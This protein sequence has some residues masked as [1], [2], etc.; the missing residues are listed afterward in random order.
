MSRGISKTITRSFSLFIFG[1]LR[2]AHNPLESFITDLQMFFRNR[3]PIFPC[4]CLA[5]QLCPTL[6]D[7]VD[8]NPPASSVHGILQAR[9]LEWVAMPVSSGSSR[10]RDWTR[11]LL[12]RQI[13]YHWATQEAQSL[14]TYTH[15]HA[16]M[17]SHSVVSAS[18]WTHGLSSAKSV[19]ISYSGD[20]PDPGIEPVSLHLLDWLGD[21]LPLSHLGSPFSLPLGL[22]GDLFTASVS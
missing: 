8:C 5:A 15:L 6:C 20:L 18:L 11:V 12:G 17:F 10:P 16:W 19:G 3:T 14:Y 21:S 22:F 2:Q 1:L 4:V 13:L 9:T 7:P